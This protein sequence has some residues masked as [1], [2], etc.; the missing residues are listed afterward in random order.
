MKKTTYGVMKS[1]DGT[2][3]HYIQE[4]GHNRKPHNLNGPAMIYADGK[5]EYYINGLRMNQSQFLLISKK[6][7]YNSV[8]EEA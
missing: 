8:E 1:I 6:R 4:P 3:I 7:I 5:E 2:K